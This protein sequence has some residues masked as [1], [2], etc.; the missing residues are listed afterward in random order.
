MTTWRLHLENCL[1]EVSRHVQELNAPRR[2]PVPIA[3]QDN[4]R[5]T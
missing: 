4:A 1:S 2:S 3:A 5:E